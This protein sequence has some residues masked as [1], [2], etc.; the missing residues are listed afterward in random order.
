MIVV[1][2][3]CN[4]SFDVL[5][6]PVVTNNRKSTNTQPAKK[7]KKTTKQ[8]QIKKQPTK[9]KKIQTKQNKKEKVQYK[10]N[11]PRKT[12]KQNRTEQNEGNAGTICE[13]TYHS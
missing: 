5:R 13:K 3:K 1:A 12:N 4:N 11:K 8:T 7:N 9:Q 2:M 10:I 6:I